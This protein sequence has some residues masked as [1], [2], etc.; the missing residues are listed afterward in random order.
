MNCRIIDAVCSGKLVLIYGRGRRR[1]HLTRDVPVGSAHITSALTLIPGGVASCTHPW[2]GRL[3]SQPTQELGDSFCHFRQL[4]VDFR[5]ALKIQHFP[6]EDASD[7]V[8][9]PPLMGRIRWPELMTSLVGWRVGENTHTIN[10]H[11]SHG[12]LKSMALTHDGIKGEHR[13]QN[14]LGPR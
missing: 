1:T 10:T 4:F 11:M 13:N 7:C 12:R 6:D 9:M 14:S 2:I 3:P 5:H 8:T